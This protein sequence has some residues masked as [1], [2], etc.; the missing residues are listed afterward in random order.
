MEEHDEQ[1]RKSMLQIKSLLENISEENVVAENELKQKSIAAEELQKITELMK[2]PSNNYMIDAPYFT[3]PKTLTLKNNDKDLDVHSELQ[4]RTKFMKVPSNNYMIDAPYFTSSKT[5]TLKN[6]DKD[7]DVHGGKKDIDKTLSNAKPE[8]K[9]KVLENISEENLLTENE[10][11][12]KSITAEELQKIAKSEIKGKVKYLTKKTLSSKKLIKTPKEI[13][14]KNETLKATSNTSQKLFLKMIQRQKKNRKREEHILKRLDKIRIS[15]LPP[16]P[17]KVLD[18]A[19]ESEESG[20]IVECVDIHFLE[21]TEMIKGD[22]IVPF[23]PHHKQLIVNNL[24]P[25]LFEV[26]TDISCDMSLTQINN[27]S[28]ILQSERSTLEIHIYKVIPINQKHDWY[29]NLKKRKQMF[30]LTG[31]KLIEIGVDRRSRLYYRD[32]NVALECYDGQFRDS[33]K[34][35]FVYEAARLKKNAKNRSLLACFDNFGNGIVYD[36]VGGIRLK[37]NQSEGIVFDAK[38]GPFGRWKWHNLNDP[39]VLEQVFKDNCLSPTDEFISKINDDIKGVDFKSIQNKLNEEIVAI[40]LDNFIKKTSKK[41]L[42]TY[43]PFEIRSKVLKLNEY[44]SLKIINQS[45]V[46]LFFRCAEIFLKISLGIKLMS[47]EIIG[48]ELLDIEEVV[49]PYD[50]QILK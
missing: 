19:E 33:K 6:N 14:L 25:L 22:Q 47:N 13:K 37:Y 7:L 23:S 5:L 32:G 44:F 49:T 35:Y 10:L 4:K 39:P 31:E 3:S 11:K 16:I 26:Q 9:G 48:T 41:V 20:S 24:K 15:D 46:Y 40:E 42:M 45:K 17:L 12:Q 43:K 34:R 50:N 36:N 18:E 8:I 29:E 27:N 2:V 30:Y 28:R 38:I 21:P 1:C